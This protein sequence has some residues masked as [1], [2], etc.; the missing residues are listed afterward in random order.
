MNT[1][2]HNMDSS[3]SPS[4][5]DM[6]ICI[7]CARVTNCG[8]YHFVEERHEQPHMTENPTFEP[9][10][11]SP[12][13]HV[14]IRTIQNEEDRKK[15]MERMWREHKAETER[16]MAKQQQQNNNTNGDEEAL[17]GETT[18]DLSGVTTYEYDVVECEDYVEDMGAWVRNMPQEIRDANPNFVPS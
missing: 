18:Y 7:N 8:A 12:T 17:Y 4:K 10:D 2:N 5:L 6:C 15:E 13:I 3:S 1:V 9:Q 11:G 14:N 16:A